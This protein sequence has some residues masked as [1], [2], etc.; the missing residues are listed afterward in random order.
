MRQEETFS[1][2]EKSI[3]DSLPHLFLIGKTQEAVPEANAIASVLNF[4]ALQNGSAGMH[5]RQKV[6]KSL[7]FVLCHALVVICLSW[8][9]KMS[10]A[11]IS[12]PFK[13]VSPRS[14][15]LFS[16]SNK[17]PP[18]ESASPSRLKKIK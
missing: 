5:E 3:T 10:I 6:I 11:P 9:P 14:S 17:R 8:C 18:L 7:N 16:L 1:E 4:Y 15:N 2:L 13:L 12:A